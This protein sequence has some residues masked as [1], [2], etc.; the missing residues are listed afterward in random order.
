ME[1]EAF[2]NEELE[3]ARAYWRS[4]APQP[5]AI[6]YA[7]KALLDA[8]LARA[9]N[10]LAWVIGDATAA[11]N[12]LYGKVGAS[13]AGSWTRRGDLPYS[14]IIAT[15]SGAGTANAIQA[16]TSLPVSGSSLVL[17]NIVTDNTASPVTA[18]FNGGSMLT[19]K[20]NSGNDPVIGG[21]KAGMVVLGTVSGSTFRLVSDQS[22]AANLAA[23]EAARAAAEAAA[24]AAISAAGSNAAFSTKALA[25]AATI[26]ASVHQLM[27]NGLNALGDGLGGAY[28]DT[29]NGSTDTFTTNSGTRTWYRAA[30]IS[31]SRLNKALGTLQLA[32]F[33]QHEIYKNFANN[34]GSANDVTLS[35]LL[36]RPST[37][38]RGV[39]SACWVAEQGQ[40]YCTWKIGGTQPT[41]QI[42]LSRHDRTGAVV[43]FT[44]VI[45]YLGHGQQLDYVY[46]SGVFTLIAQ[47]GDRRG[48]SAFTYVPGT[49]STITNLR[50]YTLDDAGVTSGGIALSLDK[51]LVLHSFS[52][53][54]DEGSGRTGKGW[55]LFD[56]F[57]LLSG[58]TGNRIDEPGTLLWYGKQPASPG[59]A[60]EQGFAFDGVN[61]YQI[62]SAGAG[63]FTGSIMCSRLVDGKLLWTEDCH[64]R[65]TVTGETAITSYEMEGIQFVVPGPGATPQLWVAFGIGDGGIST[66]KNMTAPLLYGQIGAHS[67]NGNRAQFGIGQFYAGGT[68]KQAWFGPEAFRR[69]V[70]RPSPTPSDGTEPHAAGYM[71]GTDIFKAYAGEDLYWAGLSTA[72]VELPIFQQDRT[73]GDVYMPGLKVT[74]CKVTVPSD[75][76]IAGSSART[77]VNF[78]TS[79]FA[80]GKAGN[81]ATITVNGDGTVTVLK[82]GN[83]RVRARICFTSGVTVGETLGAYIVRNS[84]DSALEEKQAART[85]NEWLPVE[86]VIICVAGDT[87]R[88]E[89]YGSNATSKVISSSTARTTLNIQKV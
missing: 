74:S 76:T 89:A 82:A 80:A 20:T 53:Y 26:A 30:D 23:A 15:N 63:V 24:A 50:Q 38:C 60:P 69:G 12:G 77:K 48:L 54:Y 64:P 47:T 34:D 41:E 13:G 78:N 3:L 6:V 43:D 10:T 31:L 29:N 17:L 27:L 42:R 40:W 58:A 66:R 28:I 52:P 85:V 73:S 44:D 83:Y 8:D 84:T 61:I 32:Q 22:S 35:I 62:N 14:F 71:E 19:V 36:P 18:S 25:T 2:M 86:D 59:G 75:Q 70:W 4:M 46:Y 51:K 81:S 39:Q 9:A 1:Q 11:N 5:K 67:V 88:V 68:Y 56:L 57:A 16:T 72:N 55:K 79:Q 33:G 65:F 45:D 21:L 37:D 49:P 7:S 87:L